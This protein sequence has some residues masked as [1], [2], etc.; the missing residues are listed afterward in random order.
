MPLRSG[1]NRM[2][3]R[4][5][6][7]VTGPKRMSSTP[8]QAVTSFEEIALRCCEPLRRRCV[9]ERRHVGMRSSGGRVELGMSRA[10]RS[11]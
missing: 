11:H 6:S 10:A 3:S 2:R 7:S 5:F 9:A 8:A 4:R 1:Q